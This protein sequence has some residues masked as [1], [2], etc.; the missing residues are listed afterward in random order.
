MAIEGKQRALYIDLNDNDSR[1]FFMAAASLT[2]RI[3]YWHR[4][5]SELGWVS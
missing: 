5:A 3:A 4:D 1:V 2:S